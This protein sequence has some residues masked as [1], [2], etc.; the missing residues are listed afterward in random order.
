VRWCDHVVGIYNYGEPM[1]R[2]IS[3]IAEGDTCI[4]SAPMCAEHGK[5]IGHVTGEEPETVDMC[6]AHHAGFGGDVIDWTRSREQ[7]EE[8]RREAWAQCRRLGFCIVR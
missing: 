1:L 7:L 5:Q 6:P 3:E 8:M 2:T 4:C